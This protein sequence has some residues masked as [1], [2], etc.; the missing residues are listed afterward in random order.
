MLL[1]FSG[2]SMVYDLNFIP[3]NQCLQLHSRLD[4]HSTC[5]FQVFS[6]Q[7]HPRYF[8]SAASSRKEE[9]SFAINENRIHSLRK[10]PHWPSI[11]WFPRYCWYSSTRSCP[12]NKTTE[13]CNHQHSWR[14][15][16]SR[17]TRRTTEYF[18][19]VPLLFS[20]GA[21][22]Y[23]STSFDVFMCALQKEKRMLFE[24]SRKIQLKMISERVYVRWKLPLE[25]TMLM[26]CR[27]WC[28]REWKL[29]VA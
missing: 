17:N 18:F 10:S 7:I 24:W 12:K 2:S 13:H 15:C 27:D 8:Q 14:Q 4:F 22:D 11:M 9:N 26:M 29:M 19:I 28:S 16:N 3:K 20:G 23:S 5:K 21:V 25:F 6:M 1:S